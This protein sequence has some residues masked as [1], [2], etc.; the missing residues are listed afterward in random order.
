MC[1]Q[2]FVP[3]LGKGKILAPDQLQKRGIVLAIRCYLC[4]ERE[5]IVDYLLL[6]CAKARMS[7]DLL[8]SLLEVVWMNPSLV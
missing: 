7:W 4:Q 6:H 1:S 2:K 8:F 3:M 5:E